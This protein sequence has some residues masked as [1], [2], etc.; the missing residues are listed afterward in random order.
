MEEFN[1]KFN[2]LK[3]DIQEIEKL[4]KAGVLRHASEVEDHGDNDDDQPF[5]QQ[6][7]KDW[8]SLFPEAYNQGGCGSCWSFSTVGVVSAFVAKKCNAAYVRLS[9]Q[10]MVDCD[11]YQKGCTKGGTFSRAYEYIVNNGLTTE[12]EYPYIADLGRCKIMGCKKVTEYKPYG[13]VTFAKYCMKGDPF[14]GAC[15]DKDVK[16]FINKGPITA[17]IDGGILKDY[18][19]G[20]INTPASHVTHGVIIVAFGDCPIEEGSAYKQSNL[21]CFK[22]RNSWGDTWGEDGYGY[23]QYTRDDYTNLTAGGLGEYMYQPSDVK[24]DCKK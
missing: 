23:V 19:G 9:E 18:T 16:R 8:T 13:S 1:A 3:I 21:K 11:E 6:D 2:N 24:S 22:I 14:G 15:T 10:Q 4:R 5:V 17:A 20:V 7:L 12:T